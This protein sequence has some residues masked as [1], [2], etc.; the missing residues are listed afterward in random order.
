MAV[1]D[2]C[3]AQQALGTHAR[4][5]RE[6]CGGDSPAV[7]L[8]SDTYWIDLIVGDSLSFIVGVG[9]MGEGTSAG[10]EMLPM[11]GGEWAMA[12][13]RVPRD[14]RILVC[15]REGLHAASGAV[16]RQG[17]LLVRCRSCCYRCQRRGVP[18]RACLH[19]L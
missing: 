7:G 2:S 19:I 1:S 11:G 9:W 15:S 8:A 5:H 18:A 14:D 13:Q 4:T 16:R 6:G 10:A 12:Q 17:R 3:D